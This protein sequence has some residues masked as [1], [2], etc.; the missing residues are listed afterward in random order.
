MN[1]TLL[2]LNVMIDNTKGRTIMKIAFDIDGVLTD[3]EK[4]Q[5]EYGSKFFKKKYNHDVYNV[6]GYGIKEVFNCTDQQEIKFWVKNTLKYMNTVKPRIN[7][8]ITTKKLHEEGD[9]IFIIS[10]RAKTS[11]NSILGLLMR[12]LVIH[13]LKQN[14]IIYDEIM[15]CSTENSSVDKFNICKQYKI[16]IMIEDKKEN[17][18]EICKI[19]PTI[20]F[21][22]KN[23]QGCTGK[24]IYRVNNFDEVYVKV[25]A[26]K[27]G[28]GKSFVVLNSKQRSNLDN[29][30]MLSYYKKLRDYYLNLPYDNLLAKEKKENSLHL[31]KRLQ[32]IFNFMYN[33]IS[34]NSKKLTDYH[35]VIFAANH[36]H[37]FDPLVLMSNGVTDFRL[38]AKQELQQQ[39]IGK[40]FE[41]IN[42][43][44]VDKDD[45]FSGEIARNELIK[46]V[47]HGNNIMTFPEGTRNKTQNLLLPFKYG[48]VAIAQ[49]TGA[50]IIPCALNKEY[51]FR[52]GRLFVN[53]G[54]ELYVHPT[55][56]LDDANQK[57][58]NEI[59][60]LLLEV[61]ENENRVK[62]KIK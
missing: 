50:P 22:T 58:E 32:A 7:A 24:N 33:P 30:E 19:I 3:I 27:R 14:N 36:L 56:S 40:L 51:H 6:N 9:Q 29:N 43:I 8:D 61:K 59:L 12:R 1:L 35:G 44:F 48:T 45:P 20:C 47:L 46:T 16:D 2:L 28:V 37:A 53:I 55:D 25:N 52:S 21:T 39:R 62:T 15:F 41:Y 34:L 18:Q 26:I 42:S 49:I 5:L 38:L 57:L 11:E 17:I 54:N 23:N 31:L 10:S 60:Q 4:F 13:W